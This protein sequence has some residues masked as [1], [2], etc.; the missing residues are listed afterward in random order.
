MRFICDLQDLTKM[1]KCLE[2][3]M[4]PIGFE[5]NGDEYMSLAAQML[6]HQDL[7]DFMLS[8]EMPDR[9]DCLF[10]I[11]EGLTGSE[12]PLFGCHTLALMAAGLW[13]DDAEELAAELMTDEQW[14]RAPCPLRQ[15]ATFSRED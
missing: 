10:H 2:L 9:T 15:A 5:M 12:D 6:G 8:L 1:A 4:S 14:V 3:R 7:D 13:K 11:M